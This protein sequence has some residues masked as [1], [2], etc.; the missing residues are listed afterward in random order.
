MRQF[1]DCYSITTQLDLV[2]NSV[3][4]LRVQGKKAELQRR[5]VQ[6]KTA[7][8]EKDK[9][10]SESK[11]DFD[12]HKNRESDSFTSIQ[13]TQRQKVESG[14]VSPFNTLLLPPA[15]KLST[16]RIVG[17]RALSAPPFDKKYLLEARSSNLIEQQLHN[18]QS[19][20]RTD[21]DP[22]ARET[23]T[24]RPKSAVP[25]GNKFNISSMFP[26][27]ISVES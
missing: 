9:T 26:I 17:R 22:E 14:A 20:K 1:G 6:L 21:K 4:P 16:T 10:F 19:G 3:M 15:Y 12:D 7:Q 18:S 5:A 25:I 13:E 2:N 23:S 11:T 24:R 27:S 8:L